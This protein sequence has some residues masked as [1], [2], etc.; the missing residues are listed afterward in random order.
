MFFAWFLAPM[1]VAKIGVKKI[2][3]AGGVATALQTIFV[4]RRNKSA[5]QKALKEYSNVD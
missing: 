1:A 2:P 4:D 5:K 3:I